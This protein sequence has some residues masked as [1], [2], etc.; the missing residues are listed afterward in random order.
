M[1]MTVNVRILGIE[2]LVAVLERLSSGS[3]VS[4]LA[5]R[6]P[7]VQ[8]PAVTAQPIQVMPAAV[9]TTPAAAVP[10]TAVPITAAP[11]SVV[12]TVPVTAQPAPAVAVVPTTPVT[13]TLDQITLAAMQLMDAE[14]MTELQGLL[15]VFNVQSLTA[16]PPEH[17]GAFATQLR[18]M[19]VKI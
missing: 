5:V 9:P 7:E 3:Q 13:Y 11:A 14:R 17:Y 2:S 4:T 10:A 6:T 16:L 1:E 15:A 18:A 19:G 12:A 8:P